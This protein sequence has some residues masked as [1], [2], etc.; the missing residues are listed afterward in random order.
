LDNLTRDY[1][2][3][4][5]MGGS[6]NLHGKV[7]ILLQTFLSRGRVNSFSLMSDLSYITQVGELWELGVT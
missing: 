5:V 1:C 7:N 6:E 2:E 4:E 3:V